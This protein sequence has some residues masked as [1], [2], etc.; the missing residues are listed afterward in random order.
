MPRPHLELIR[1]GRE[2][3]LKHHGLGEPKP[4]EGLQVFRLILGVVQRV[5]NPRGLDVPQSRDDVPDVP[6][7]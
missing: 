4:G 2:Q 5:S 1:R 3:T 7:P 6:V